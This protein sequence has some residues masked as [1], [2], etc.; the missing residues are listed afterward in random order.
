[1]SEGFTPGPWNNYQGDDIYCVYA[2][3]GKKICSIEPVDI[4]GWN[5][6]HR[7]EAEANEA[8]IIAAPELL[9]GLKKMLDNEEQRVFEKW[10][11]E[12]TPSGDV[13]SVQGQWL[14]SSEYE[15]FL[16]TWALQIA[17]LSKARGTA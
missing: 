7:E 11:L 6:V 3:S 14:D 10:L 5:A 8:L 1:M 9:A 15:D 16:D 12:K 13:S 2:E 17:A 4:V